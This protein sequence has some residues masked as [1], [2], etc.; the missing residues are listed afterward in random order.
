MDYA[1]RLSDQLR[2]HLRALRKQRGLTQA[3]LGL[4][5]GIGQARVAEIESKPGL[6]SVEQF[7]QIVSALG[8]TL[9]LRDPADDPAATLAPSRGSW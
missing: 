5:L 9:V 3:Q 8:A 7:I 4:R 2:P 1:I 6:I